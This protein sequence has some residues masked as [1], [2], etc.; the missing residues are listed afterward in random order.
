[1]RS[2]N[3]QGQVSDFVPCNVLSDNSEWNQQVVINIILVI[4][5]SELE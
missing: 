5:S 1:M 3:N 4:V 2:L